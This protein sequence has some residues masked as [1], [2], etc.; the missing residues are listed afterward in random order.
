MGG[1][2]VPQ[3][4]SLWALGV[5]DKLGIQEFE[6]NTCGGGGT[7]WYNCRSTLFAWI[8]LCLCLGYTQLANNLVTRTNAPLLSL[9]KV[10]QV[11][12]M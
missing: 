7:G 8:L 4:L 1:S 11:H 12:I 3:S 9:G 6:E 10:S 2:F 5:P